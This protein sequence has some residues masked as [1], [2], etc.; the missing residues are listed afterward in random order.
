MPPAAP[1]KRREGELPPVPGKPEVL[2]EGLAR[3]GRHRGAAPSC[4]PLQ[5]VREVVGQCKCCALHTF[6]L[7]AAPNQSGSTRVDEPDM[8]TLLRSRPAVWK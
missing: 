3:H 4:L 5:R 1:S 6:I 2:A 8:Q 7:A